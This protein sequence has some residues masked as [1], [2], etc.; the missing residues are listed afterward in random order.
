M[1]GDEETMIGGPIIQ[2]SAG[3]GL[4][5]Q[6]ERTVRQQ[7]QRR[8]NPRHH[9]SIEETLIAEQDDKTG[10]EK[11]RFKFEKEKLKPELEL[12]RA[13][14]LAQQKSSERSF[15]LEKM[16]L[17]LMHQES[18]CRYHAFKTETELKFKKLEVTMMQIRLKE[19]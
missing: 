15:Q 2:F 8:R 11:N 7:K 4:E 6:E 9:Q 13:E 5:E 17:D 18:N 12:R 3:G 16:K 10:L 14:I 1:T 19:N